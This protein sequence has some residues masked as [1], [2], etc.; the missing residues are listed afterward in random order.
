M[1][2]RRMI[3]NEIMRLVARHESQRTLTIIETVDGL[4][5]DENDAGVCVESRDPG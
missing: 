1:N 3:P 5:E 4:N 2:F